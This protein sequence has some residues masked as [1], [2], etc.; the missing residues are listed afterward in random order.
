MPDKEIPSNFL[1]CCATTES[2]I[3]AFTFASSVEVAVMVVVPI[4]KA[5]TVPLVTVATC[6][7]D[8]DQV[9][10]LLALIG[11]TLRVKFD[12]SLTPKERIVGD[13]ASAVGV[14]LPC[15]PNKATSSSAGLAAT[16]LPHTLSTHDG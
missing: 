7:F 4:A 1:R 11:V 3:V 9:T 8:D 15:S 6:S 2:V 13:N 10:L 12:V 16:L 5:V 14:T